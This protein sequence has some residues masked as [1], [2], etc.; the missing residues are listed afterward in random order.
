MGLGKTLSIITLC[1][2]VLSNPVLTAIPSPYIKQLPTKIIASSSAS[3]S[4][5][6]ATDDS[7]T[8]TAAVGDGND[9]FSNSSNNSATV[10][11]PQRSS[12]SSSTN[13]NINHHHKS[14]ISH[15]TSSPII[16]KFITPQPP[17]KKLF[18]CI[19]IIAPVNTLKN[20]E[21]EFN[22]WTPKELK[23]YTKVVML[24]SNDEGCGGSSASGSSKNKMTDRLLILRNWQRRGGVLI[25]GYEM[26]RNLTS[27]ESYRLSKSNANTT[28]NNNIITR[29]S[30]F[31][32]IPTTNTSSSK[33]NNTTTPANATSATPNITIQPNISVF[34]SKQE[35]E[36]ED[37]MSCLVDPG[38]DLVVADEA[39][40]IK[41]SQAKVSVALKKI[42]TKRRIALTGSPLQNNLVSTC[43]V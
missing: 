22:R 19:L 30:P 9:N 20:W 37:A 35:K 25:M 15:S 16:T 17:I 36:Y 18:H 12:S 34:K 33:H 26:F 28:N 38:P 7:A 29:N 41:D 39:H 6:S 5:S 4:S 8:V 23:T 43:G 42:R 24:S 3:S 1:L 13:N 2:T 32:P 40:V 10:N 27:R 21:V 14:P 31:S 11:S